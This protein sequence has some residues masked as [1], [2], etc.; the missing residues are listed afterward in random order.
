M[1]P[2]YAAWP[3]TEHVFGCVLWSMLVVLVLSRFRSSTPTRVQRTLLW[4][5]CIGLAHSATLIGV[6]V[7]RLRPPAR[8]PGLDLGYA[9]GSLAVIVLIGGFLQYL[10]ADAARAGRYLKFAGPTM[11]L[12]F[13]C[14]LA[15]WAW[16]AATISRPPAPLASLATIAVGFVLIVAGAG[17]AARLVAGTERGLLLGAI[18]FYALG[19]GLRLYMLASSFRWLAQPP[20]VAPVPFAPPGMSTVY[21]AIVNTIGV[22]LFGYLYLRSHTAN[23]RPDAAALEA[24]VLERTSEL[25]AAM[26]ELSLA[27]LRLVEQSN[28]DSLTGARNRRYFDEALLQEWVRASREGRSLAVGLVDLDRF[29]NIN[30]QYGHPA[31]DQ[32]LACV[33][34][35]LF[36][37]AGRPDLVARYGGDEFVML[38]PNTDQQSAL[39]ILD[40]ARCEIE[41]LGNG[42]GL[43]LTVSVGAAACIPDSGIEP[44]DLIQCADDRLYAAK[45]AGRNR[46]SIAGPKVPG[47]A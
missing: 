4:G 9:L 7:L 21:G 6:H 35:V 33:A 15:H 45:Q 32:C 29:K 47:M 25:Q 1:G 13:S 34:G 20:F 19:T 30:D 36:D 10:S 46:V 31:G 11:A 5:F 17:F 18:S 14:Y 2:L 24:R 38:L 43:A 16:A 41:T 23:V 39:A 40:K 37:C 12:S 27:N 44:E 3:G 8:I 26:D 28:V 42:Q 22:V